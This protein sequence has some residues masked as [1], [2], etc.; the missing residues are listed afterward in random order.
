LDS[1]VATLFK[2]TGLLLFLECSPE[3]EIII[4]HP[5]YL[6]MHSGIQWSGISD[7]ISIKKRGLL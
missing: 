1:K 6:R 4:V 3:S 5:Q 7:V 2:P